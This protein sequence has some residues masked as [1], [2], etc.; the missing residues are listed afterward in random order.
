P[1]DQASEI[2]RA[3]ALGPDR[4]EEEVL[5]PDGHPLERPFLDPLRGDVLEADAFHTIPVAAD[6]VGERAVVLFGVRLVDR[7]RRGQLEREERR[8]AGEADDLALHADRVVVRS[9]GV[10]DANGEPARVFV[11]EPDRA[12]RVA[13]GQAYGVPDVGLERQRAQFELLPV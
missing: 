10:A 1:G 8:R 7:E 3:L 9:E 12:R 6:A 11:R 2:T 5:V 4:R 13:F